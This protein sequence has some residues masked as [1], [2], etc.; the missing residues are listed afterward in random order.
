M[1]DAKERIMDNMDAAICNDCAIS[2]GAKFPSGHVCTM[3]QGECYFC[4]DDTSCCATSDYDWPGKK[5]RPM[6]REF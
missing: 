5:L 6:E 1:N 3:W 4:K 2:L